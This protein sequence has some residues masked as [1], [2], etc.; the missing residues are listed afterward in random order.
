MKNRFRVF[1]SIFQLMRDDFPFNSTGKLASLWF[2]EII[3]QVDRKAISSVLDIA[4]E[5]EI[6][7]SETLKKLKSIWIP[8]KQYHPD[9]KFMHNF[10]K[11]DDIGLKAAVKSSVR[12]RLLFPNSWA[13]FRESAFEE[14]GILESIGLWMLLN[15]NKPC[16]FLPV[17]EEQL[18]IKKLFYPE[19]IQSF[20]LFKE[21]MVYK[22][23]DVRHYPWSQILEYRTHPQFEFY[24]RKMSELSILLSM[25]DK[26]SVEEIVEEIYRSDMEK[27][28]K[29]LQPSWKVETIKAVASV[30]PLP[31]PIN[32]ISLLNSVLDMKKDIDCMKKYG[33]MYFYMD[34]K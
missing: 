19:N 26:K 27:L 14:V 6:L 32:P 11:F 3:L 22:V 13:H 20:N 18:A 28:T 25:E 17:H 21:I 9:Y 8:I 2:D 23:P 31:L 16:S 1:A 15:K 24:R 29:L 34:L 33:W 4:A 10:S 5:D 7:D 30:I 12:E